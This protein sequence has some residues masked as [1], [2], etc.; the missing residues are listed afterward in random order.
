LYCEGAGSGWQQ[1]ARMEF[2]VSLIWYSK[3]PERSVSLTV[4]PRSRWNPSWILG[5]PSPFQYYPASQW[6]S[7]RCA[8]W[9]RCCLPPS[10][11]RLEAVWWSV[12]VLPAI[13]EEHDCA[14]ILRPMLARYLVSTCRV[15]AAE[16]LML[17]IAA[18]VLSKGFWNRPKRSHLR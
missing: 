1:R 11:L 13:N 8:R 10:S 3:L 18:T 7:P 15:S 6:G 12:P 16:S 5:A 9:G 17:W 14:H 4:A 2:A